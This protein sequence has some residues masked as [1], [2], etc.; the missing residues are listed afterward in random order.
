MVA[1]RSSAVAEDSS[2]A[3]WAGLL[4]TFLNTTR[5]DLIE[6]IRKCWGSIKSERALAY[7]AEQNVLWKNEISSVLK[8]S[9]LKS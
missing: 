1:V 9:L 4:D 6:N 8:M 2:S 3:S 5:E 7:A